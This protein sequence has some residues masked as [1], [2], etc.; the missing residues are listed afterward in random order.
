MCVCIQYILSDCAPAST[1]SHLPWSHCSVSESLG[2]SQSRDL[3]GHFTQLLLEPLFSASFW[4]RFSVLL[5]LWLNPSILWNHQVSHDLF[6][7]KSL[8]HFLI[9]Y[10]RFL[11]PYGQGQCLTWFCFLTILPLPKDVGSKHF[12]MDLL[13][14]KRIV[15]QAWVGFFMH[16]S[17]LY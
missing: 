12:L 14:R 5:P 4:N 11:S 16:S 15:L 17:A 7:A 1:S 6:I 3:P 2:E 10:P 9:T 13:D 8:L